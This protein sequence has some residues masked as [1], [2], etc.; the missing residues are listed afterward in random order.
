LEAIDPENDAA[1]LARWTHDSA[2]MRLVDP[3]PLRPMT[4]AQVKERYND[5]ETDRTYE[6]LI[7][8]RSDDRAV[9][10]I[11]LE[12]LQWIHGSAN[13]QLGIVD[14][15]DR[16]RGYG[17]EALSLIIYYAFGELDFHRL[18]AI[19]PGDNPGGIAFLQRMGFEVEVRRREAVQRDG[20]RWD[21]WHL[22]LLTREGGKQGGGP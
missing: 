11:R 12:R 1:T 6:F 2:F 20:R 10:F 14:P 18:G 21:L 19:C 13:V 5:N 22:G 3:A 7:R 17:G 4:T 9:G 16:R 15:A 8:T